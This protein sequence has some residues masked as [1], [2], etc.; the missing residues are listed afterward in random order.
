MENNKNQSWNN[1]QDVSLLTDLTTSDD[2]ISVKKAAGS[3]LGAIA[4]DLL[5]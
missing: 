5:S 1:T 4:A 3:V 2:N